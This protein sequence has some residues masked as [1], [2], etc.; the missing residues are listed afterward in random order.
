MT[1]LAQR[2]TLVLERS[3]EDDEW[4]VVAHLVHDSGQRERKTLTRR[5]TREEA[6]EALQDLWSRMLAKT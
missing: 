6:A 4:F 3:I 1:D 5:K 2:A